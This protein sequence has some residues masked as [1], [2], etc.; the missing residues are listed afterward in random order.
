MDNAMNANK[1][2]GGLGLEL[3][4]MVDKVNTEITQEELHKMV[5]KF[6][7]TLPSINL[8]EIFREIKIAARQAS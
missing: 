2:Q 5:E 3:N 8:D 1:K 4:S 6:V 7:E